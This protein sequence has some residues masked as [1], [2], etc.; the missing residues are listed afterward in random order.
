M[1]EKFAAGAPDIAFEV[2]SS[3]SAK[4]LQFKIDAY[5]ENGSK[6]VCC[7]Y[8]EQ[9]RISVFMPGQWTELKGS[10]SLEF[11]SLLPGFSLPLAEIFKAS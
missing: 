5:L 1:R 3:D 8:P 10:D 4:R 2:I 6:A 9:K 11:P 7:I